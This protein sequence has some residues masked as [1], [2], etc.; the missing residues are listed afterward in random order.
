[1]AQTTHAFSGFALNFGVS[2]QADLSFEAL[3]QRALSDLC[4][5]LDLIVT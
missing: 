3:T 4:A 2:P 1:M 5:G